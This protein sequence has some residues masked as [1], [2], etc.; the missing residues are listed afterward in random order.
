MKLIT[1]LNMHKRVTWPLLSALIAVLLTSCGSSTNST[2]NE[3]SNETINDSAQT[4]SDTATTVTSEE[5]AINQIGYL[6]ASP[7]IAVLPSLDATH[8]SLVNKDSGETVYE[9]NLSNTQ[10]WNSVA[11]VET[12]QADF[13]DFNT[14]GTYVLKVSGAEDKDIVIG[15]D[16]YLDLHDAAVKS[17]YFNRSSTEITEPL[18]GQWA[19]DAGHAD[20]NVMVHSSASSSARPEGTLL[21]SSKGWY[22][23]G[24]FGK[25]V[26]N[27]GIATYTML[28]AFE[29]FPDFYKFREHAIPESGDAV[30]DLLDE[31]KW[32]LDWLATMQDTD[33][34]V[35][36]KLTTLGWPGK[37]MPAQDTR[38]RYVIGKSTTAALSFAAVMSVASRV[39]SDYENEFPGVSQQW[40]TAAESAWD[41]AIANDNLAYSQPSDVESGQYGDDYFNDEF[42]WAAAELFITTQNAEYLQHYQNYRQNIST[43]GWQYVAA[44]ASLSL[45]SK[46]EQLVAEPLYSS[47]QTELTTLADQFVTQAALNNYDTAMQ[48]SDF[49]WGSNSVVL[50]KAVILMKAHALTAQVSYRNTA[51]SL[52]SYVLGVNPTGYSYV[53][54]FGSKQ[55]IE[56]HH[57]ASYSDNIDA[58]IPG[59]VVGGPQNGQQDECNY[60]S[61]DPAMSYLDDWCSYSTN[62]IAINWTAPLIYVLAALNQP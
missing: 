53:T 13:S 10:T 27:S 62:E 20:L 39:Y 1:N 49:V 3:T 21:Q 35:Y 6:T 25:Y 56:P 51:V 2:N 19:R 23:A 44:L 48:G 24:D 12:K 4:D 14:A 38:D 60:P 58:P 34:S 41:W 22:D 40:L 37:E 50:N 15:T 47:V 5:I 54:G 36:H 29:H 30:P 52:L 61:N 16:L 59:M 57:R 8:F 28:A 43:P 33:G 11:N 18:G 31:I 42:S 55:P 7:K 46:G 32:N 45:L 17:Y 9:G 26:V